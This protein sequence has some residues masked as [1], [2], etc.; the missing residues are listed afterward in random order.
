MNLNPAGLQGEELGA[1]RRHKLKEFYMKELFLTK[2]IIDFKIHYHLNVSP[3][4]I[5]TSAGELMTELLP[6]AIELHSALTP[7][8]YKVFTSWARDMMPSAFFSFGFEL[9]PLAQRK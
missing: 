6:F 5:N 3:T 9:T 4:T 2:C 7:S 8:V 1:H